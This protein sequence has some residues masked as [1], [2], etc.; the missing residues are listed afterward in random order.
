MPVLKEVKD[1]NL[2]WQHTSVSGLVFVCISGSHPEVWRPLLQ[3]QW[4]S[5]RDWLGRKSN[6]LA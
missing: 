6:T 1:I 3:Q 5:L 2:L 4:D